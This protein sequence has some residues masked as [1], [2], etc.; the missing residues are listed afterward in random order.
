LNDNVR[1]AI[2][3]QQRI[4]GMSSLLRPHF[5]TANR[6]SDLVGNWFERNRVVFG[7]WTKIGWAVRTRRFLA[8]HNWTF[9]SITSEM[10]E[11]FT[12]S[13]ESISISDV[14]GHI[15]RCFAENDATKLKQLVESWMIIKVFSSRRHIF[16]EA[17]AAHKEGFFNCTVSLLT[18]HTEGVMRDFLQ[19]YLDSPNHRDA[20]KNIRKELDQYVLSI[21]AKN[22]ISF[23]EMLR[24][25][26]SWGSMES[27]FEKRNEIAHG[28]AVQKN[29]EADSLRQFLF[30]D[31]VFRVCRAMIEADVQNGETR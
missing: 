5:E 31:E 2:E 27:F 25:M 15:V 9:S 1:R 16:S 12:G 29:N 11:H 19:F 28:R 14:D 4:A 30:I 7:D 13:E 22:F 8:E 3:I 26:E 18:I 21:A 20:T 10:V 17:I 24:C 23:S 6:I